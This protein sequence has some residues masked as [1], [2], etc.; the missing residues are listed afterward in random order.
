VDH[1]NDMWGVIRRIRNFVDIK[2]R[3]KRMPFVKI[4]KNKAYFKRYQ[5]KYR[6]R[7]E[8]KTDYQ[9]RRRL[10]I[11]DKDK[12]ASRKYRFVVRRT[13]TKIIC[14]V[15]YATLRGDEV[16]C[17]ATSKEL[18][19]YGL[20]AG[21]ANYAAAYC[22]G[23][24]CARRL[25]TKLK[26][27][28][29]YKGEPEATGGYYDVFQKTADKERRPFKAFLDIGLTRST[30]GNRAFG[31]LKGACDGGLAI[32]HSKNIFPGYEK[33]DKKETFDVKKHK[34]HIFGMHV[35]QYMEQVKNDEGADKQKKQFSQWLAC[36]TKNK[37]ETLEAL[38]KKI[39]AAIRSNPT[40][41]K[42]ESKET[43]QSYLDDRNTVIKTSK[44]NYVRDR[45]ITNEERK[46][47]VQDQIQAA[48]QQIKMAQ[49]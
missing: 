21:L 35:Q 1:K 12:Y 37:V 32:P 34:E 10:I 26:M 45:K 2:N 15:I 14:Q 23:L 9:Q 18:E 40:F 17:Q 6:R 27:D 4:I 41:K 31:A 44:G 36:M 16:L 19:A 30:V 29:V 43:K 33:V 42:K 24:L 13:N 28:G 8:A 39:H 38:Y 11:Q 7:V 20:T 47:K 48:L 3:K 49:S 46:K 25:L 22:T 5:V